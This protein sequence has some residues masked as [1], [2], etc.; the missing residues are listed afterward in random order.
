MSRCAG[1]SSNKLSLET[2]CGTEGFEQCYFNCGSES[3]GQD[4][5]VRWDASSLGA[6]CALMQ[7]E[8]TAADTP[9]PTPQTLWGEAGT[10]RRGPQK[11][12]DALL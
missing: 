10:L 8:P 12:F 6:A 1:V 5:E 2:R 9:V 11:Y 7:V 3:A 4:N